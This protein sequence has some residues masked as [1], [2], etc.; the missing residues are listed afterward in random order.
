MA[1]IK[2][3][4][5]DER[6]REKML[7]GGPASLTTAELIAVLLRVGTRS[8]N[9][10]DVARDMLT[11]F[12]TLKKMFNAAPAELTKI[13]GVGSAKSAAL[14]ASIE[15]ARRFIGELEAKRTVIGKPQ[16]V[17]T[18][19]HAEFIGLDREL[20]KALYLNSRNEVVDD[21]TLGSSTAST[22]LCHPQE[23]VRGLVR[24]GASRLIVVHNHPSLDPK[25]SS[26]DIAFTA[27][28]A[29]HLSYFGFELLD[30]IIVA[31]S[32][33]ASM[34]EAGNI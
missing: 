27:E 10:V 16:D 34:K 15:L 3:M 25:P 11:H 13:K 4:L 29:R 23:F 14:V 17:Y 28:L 1:R 21:E 2:D 12:G 19:Y 26:Q 31:G 6:P 22:C 18:H 9:A 8:K 7:R 20:F 32:A 5:T 30:H 33:Y 24:S